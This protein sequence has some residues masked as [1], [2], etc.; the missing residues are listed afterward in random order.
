EFAVI[1]SQF[2]MNY[3]F[4]Y[5]HQLK[6]MAI[7]VSK[8][9]HCLLELLWQWQAGDLT[10]EIAMVI[11]NHEDMRSTVEELNI[12]FYHIPVTKE[13]KEEAERKQI[14]LIKNKV[15]FIV[16]ARYMQ[17]LS[18]TFVEQFPNQVI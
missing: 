14:E 15:D 12:P 13:N 4:S 1:A 10:A 9:E 2:K 5:V 3:R 16:L 6:K 17:I 18:P 11:S 8:Q 7:F